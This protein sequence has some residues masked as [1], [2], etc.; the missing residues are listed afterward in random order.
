[1]MAAK[2]LVLTLRVL[3]HE[4]HATNAGRS[5]VEL[6]GRTEAD[7]VF[8]DIGLPDI[9]G[10]EVARMVRLSGNRRRKLVAPT[11]YGQPASGLQRLA[12]RC[13]GSPGVVEDR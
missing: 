8:V 5:E 13:F 7:C 6:V 11:G 1:M 2:P 3:G 4:V 9:D 10:Y 12:S